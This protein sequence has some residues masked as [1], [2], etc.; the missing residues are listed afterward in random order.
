MSDQSSETNLIRHLPDDLRSSE[1]VRALVSDPLPT[2][3]ALITAAL[4]SGHSQMILAGGRVAQA[5]LKGRALKQA[6]KEIDE[7]LKKGKIREDYADTKYGFQSLVELMTMIE[8]DAPEEDKLC[9]AK[10]MFVA[11]NSANAAEGEAFLR[12]QLFRLV[13]KLSGSQLVLLGVCG[14]LRKEG[15]FDANAG[16]TAQNWLSQVGKRLGYQVFSLIEQDEAVLMQHG[17]ITARLLQDRSAI[18]PRDARL[19]DLG[20]KMCELIESYSG[21]I[22]KSDSQKR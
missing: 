1:A 3:A 17:I 13:L 9:A 14:K 10:A 7:L 4:G 6:A 15:V 21:D 12:Y 18:D 2:V 8:S 20:V 19:T 11:I 22:P 5:V 16:R